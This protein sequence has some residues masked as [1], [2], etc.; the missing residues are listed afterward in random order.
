MSRREESVPH[1]PGAR[2]PGETRKTLF[3][4]LFCCP[5]HERFFFV[6]QNWNPNRDPPTC[7]EGSCPARGACPARR[8]A[9]PARQGVGAWRAQSASGGGGAKTQFGCGTPVAAIGSGGG[10]NEGGVGGGVVVDGVAVRLS[11]VDGVGDGGVVA[12]A[13]P[14]AGADVGAVSLSV[15]FA[16]DS[17]IPYGLR[18]MSGYESLRGSLRT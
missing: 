7:P 14:G 1:G 13:D 11:S 18:G 4:T 6:C 2:F 10:G 15:F 5:R 9:G 17:S 16:A 12:G 3:S 8:A